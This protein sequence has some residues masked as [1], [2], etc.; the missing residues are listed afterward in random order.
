MIVVLLLVIIAI[1]LFGAA[2]VRSAIG[3]VVSGI[4]AL[5]FLLY[6]LGTG[7]HG[8]A[9]LGLLLVGGAAVFVGAVLLKA[10]GEERAS[11]ARTQQI[12]AMSDEDRALRLT[13]IAE[14]QKAEAWQRRYEAG[15]K[16][17][18]HGRK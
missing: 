3:V 2:A 8:V 12:L 16:A 9:T 10:R 7:W 4:V 5:A 17:G 15:R 14:K 1:L 18:P 6:L 11:E 13:A